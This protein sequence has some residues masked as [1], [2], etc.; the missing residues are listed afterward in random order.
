[1]NKIILKPTALALLAFGAVTLQGCIEEEVPTSYASSEQVNGSATAQRGM[2]EGLSAYMVKHSVWSSSSNYSLDNGFPSQI[3]TR[4]ALGQDMPCYKGGYDYWSYI[5]DGSSMRYH[6]S[7]TYYYY[8]GLVSNANN[9]ISACD[10]DGATT[11][12]KASAGVGYAYRAF[13]YLDLARMYEYKTTG[14]ASLDAKAADVMGLTVPIVTEATSEQAAKSNPRV[15]FYTMYR[16]ILSDLDKA[17]SYLA[18]FKRDNKSQPDLSV[19]YGLKAR[20][21][22]ELATRFYKSSADLATAISHDSD[23]DGYASLGISTAEECYA[24]AADYASKAIN[25]GYTPSTKSDWYSATTGFNTET[26]GWMWKAILGTKEQLG[27]WY[28]SWLGTMNSESKSFGMGR[29][30]GAFRCIDASLYAQIP[31]ADWRKKV[32]VAPEDAGADTIP[33]GYATVLGDEDWKDLCPYANL[34]FHAGS[35]NISNYQVGLLCDIPLMRVEEMYLIQA[36]ALA[37]TQGLSAGKAALES[38]VN[39]YR[40]DDGS[41]AS[42]ATTL[43]DLVEDILLQKRIELW[44]EGLTYFDYKRLAHA[45]TRSYT[46]TNYLSSHRLNTKRGYVSPMMNYYIPEAEQSSNTAVVLNPDP[47]GVVVATE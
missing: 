10:I 35:G 26:S 47:S 23:D 37:Y 19:V 14:Y 3:V 11:S 28:Y 25:S 6:T 1:M 9:L 42:T 34:K 8:Y 2:L 29:Y 5:S 38:F 31:A 21:W 45:I 4:E 40:Y 13:A 44:G 24:K 41:Y 32:W 17:E 7:F 22:L 39:S 16:F 46:G 15:Q 33:A 12:T 36:E 20:F 27:S 43:D 18:S 30:G